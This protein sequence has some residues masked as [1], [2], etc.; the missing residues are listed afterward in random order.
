MFVFVA[1]TT[2]LKWVLSDLQQIFEF[3]QATVSELL[4]N[5]VAS[6]H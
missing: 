4:V 2:L 6:G 1:N 3:R 5:Y